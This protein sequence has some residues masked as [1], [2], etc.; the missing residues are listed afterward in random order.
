M[1]CVTIFI[2]EY[3]LKRFH[4]DVQDMTDYQ[5]YNEKQQQTKNQN[6]ILSWEMNMNCIMQLKRQKHHLPVN[7]SNMLPNENQF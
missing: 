2:L 6:K 5:R 1:S 7:M 4:I 3:I